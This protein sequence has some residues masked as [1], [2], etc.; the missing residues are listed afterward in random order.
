MRKK[1][2]QI[3]KFGIL[4]IFVFIVMGC[5]GT[6]NLGVYHT[7]LQTAEQEQLSYLTIDRTVGITGFNGKPV[8][9]GIARETKNTS[10]S[11]PAGLH[12]F[13]FEYHSQSGAD[14]T[15]YFAS[16]YTFSYEFV[17]GHSY[18][19]SAVSSGRTVVVNVTDK[20]NNS[21]SRRITL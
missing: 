3:G 17:A 19:I 10:I 16:N 15:T 13:R 12:S 9:W 2:Y 5:G 4:P 1:L 8:Q 11:I 14:Q 6:T 21:L 20:T 7:A 18:D